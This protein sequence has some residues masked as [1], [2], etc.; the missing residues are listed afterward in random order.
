MSEEKSI[1]G[2]L[3]R[4]SPKRRWLRRAAAL[5]AGIPVLAGLTVVGVA[6]SC[7]GLPPAPNSI[8][9]DDRLERIPA[10]GLPLEH[11]V[12]ILWNDHAVPYIVAQS[13]ADAAFAI[14]LVHAHLRLGQMEFLKRVAQGR[15]SEMA[16]PFA[17]DIDAA[18]R[19][20]DIDKAVP[21]I[22]ASL[23]DDTRAWLE[24][25]VDGVNE[26]RD[27]LRAR[28][29]ELRLLGISLDEPWT[30]ADT[31]SIGRLACVDINWGR[32][33]TF[34]S[35]RDDPKWAEYRARIQSFHEHA[36]PSFG[37]GT[38]TPIDPL[39]DYSKSGSNSWVVA[40]SRTGSGAALI[41][42]DPH[43][44][45]QQPNL[46][47]LV[48]YRTPT[49]AAVGMTFPGLPFVLVG[50]NE[51][52]AWGGTNMQAVG[53]TLF[54]VS[55]LDESAFVTRTETIGTRLWFDA[56][57]TI[58]DTPLGPLISEAPYLRNF[59]LPP[60]AIKWRGHE[61]SDEA[62]AFYRVS[63]ASDFE[64]FRAAFETFA[65]GGQNFLYADVEGN[66]GQVMAVEFVPAAGRAARAVLV[67]ANGP[68]YRW[69][70]RIKSPD[71]PYAYNPDA[72]F[73]VSANNTPT[74][75]DPPIVVTGNWNDRL[76]RLRDL[77]GAGGTLRADDMKRFQRDV[78]SKASRRNADAMLAVLGEND[79]PAAGVIAKWDGEYAVDSLG[80]SA[81][82]R[83]LHAVI[84]S[85]VAR[86]W[87][88]RIA[89]NVAGSQA[90][91]DFVREEIERGAIT[92]EDLVAAAASVDTAEAPLVAWGEMHR[93]RLRHPAG[94]A[95]LIGVS[96]RFGEQ[97][98]GGS[99]GTVF[100]TAHS[101][102]DG[103]HGVQYGTNSR[104][105]SD[106]SDP[107]ANDFVL[108]GGQD[109]H[110]GSVNY[111]DQWPLFVRGEFVRVPLLEETARREFGRV[112]RLSA[113][114]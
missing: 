3:T 69:E 64:E 34:F 62:T 10:Q 92:R 39:F 106:L 111:L 53:S 95:P 76:D 107:D 94:A 23:P 67:P 72:G 96:Y 87:G 103:V 35:L 89:G 16:G 57:A 90:V 61:P 33:F 13:D 75:L 29:H 31:L 99:T 7:V 60:S 22:E 93:L 84:T 100:K 32:W 1:D 81:Y 109:G 83:V 28:P 55:S 25:Y 11:D 73:L 108:I 12:E 15:L 17:N 27:R 9:L 98:V 40:G 80:A 8:S 45:I 18:L 58:T 101:V 38:P 112:T 65:T 50:R 30:V 42:N 21:E 85:A 41:A 51:T 71:L 2:R 52:I 63:R 114:E 6:A 113:G 54:D 88:G 91:H 74:L 14:G 48:A 20:L 86:E 66:I 97:G 110:L 26:Y 43:L 104:H 68:E 56:T 102:V 70:T 46:W 78:F 77:L 24:R 105:V 79:S 47:C 5:V 82:Q 44:G 59:G 37:P 4:T 19:T 49:H 36:T